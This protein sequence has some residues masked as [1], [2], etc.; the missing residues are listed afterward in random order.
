MSDFKINDRVIGDGKPTYF[1]ADI[2]AN[3]DG[4]LNRAKEL[5][6]L[7]RECGADAV[8]FQ[9]FKAETIV[10]STGFN[11]LGSQKSHQSKWNKSVFEVYKDASI[12]MSWTEELK[13]TAD[14]CDIHFFSSVYDMDYLDSLD[15]Y[16]PAYKI[17]S[18]DITWHEII[19]KHTTK[20]KPV[21]LATG[22]SDINE[23]LLAMSVLQNKG[24][25]IALLQCNTNYTG[26]PENFKY[27]SLN[28]LKT[29]RNLFPDVVLGLSDHTPGHSTV[30]G[31]IALGGRIIEKHFTDDNNRPGPDHPFS[32]DPASWKEMI[33]ASR[34]LELALGKE[35][36]IVED[37]EKETVILQ[38]RCIRA[39]N[40]LKQGHIIT[41]DDVEILR[42]AP[43]GSIK[44]Y[45]IDK[46]IGMVLQSDL[47]L[48]QHI[49]W[50][51]F[52]RG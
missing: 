43:Q 5:I 46:V 32:M 17:G 25:S 11:N 24:C 38:Q 19:H 21:I 23:V 15:K 51:H 44:P 3:H 33:K 28:V 50:D 26:K 8:K 20:N 12:S 6:A 42:P 10:S 7:A 13:Q 34:E 37:N 4:D 14:K 30:L 47:D 22:A 1:I 40:G 29:Y 36:K 49:T 18:G 45:E 52:K 39:K 35:H 9:H 2:A 27:I 16:V 41:R 48:G 31:C